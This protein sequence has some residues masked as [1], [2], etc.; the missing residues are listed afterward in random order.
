MESLT[1]SCKDFLNVWYKKLLIRH[2]LYYITH[3]Y[4]TGI[5]DRRLFSAF[6]I[7]GYVKRVCNDS[8]LLLPQRWTAITTRCTST[9]AA[10][11]SCCG[12]TSLRSTP[13]DRQSS[14]GSWSRWGTRTHSFFFCRAKG[15]SAF[16]RFA[17]IRVRMN[18]KLDGIPDRVEFPSRVQWT[19]SW[20]STTG[21]GLQQVVATW[22]VAMWLADEA[23]VLTGRPDEA[24][25]EQR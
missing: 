1:I 8:F 12:E 19:Q 9:T 23:A 17:V 3:L 18:R 4:Y 10:W 11:C 7:L 14:T 16:S 5:I 15:L 6:D 22:C 13:S 2:Q 24:V 21:F 25:W 20:V